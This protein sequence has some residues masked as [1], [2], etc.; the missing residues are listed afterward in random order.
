MAFY[1]I[2]QSLCN[3]RG[4]SPARVRADLN[5]SQSTMA[6]WKARSL[7]PKYDTL[8][9]IAAY[10]N[11]SVDY[12]LGKEPIKITFDATPAP[13][14]VELEQKLEDG[15]ATSEEAQRYKELMLQ[16]I[17]N[18]NATVADFV[19]RLNKYISRPDAQTPPEDK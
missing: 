2:F 15:T 17:A 12:L 8:K 18:A 7:T 16:G 4:I 14:W 13:E 10:F 9:K 3:E 6:S 5:I 19:A 11:V 1:D